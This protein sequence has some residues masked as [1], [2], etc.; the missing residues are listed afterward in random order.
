MDEIKI[1]MKEMETKGHTL[2]VRA[3]GI[4][5]GTTNSS[6]AEAKR[7]PGEN[8][9]CRALEIDQRLWPAGTMTS[10]LVPSTVSFYRSSRGMPLNGSKTALYGNA[11]YL[12][13]LHGQPSGF[14]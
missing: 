4:D 6:V 9:V 3:Y 8:P 13:V 5:L 11:C 14:I 2:D 7:A 1:F 12:S 10:P